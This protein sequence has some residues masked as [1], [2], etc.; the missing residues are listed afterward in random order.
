MIAF[1]TVAAAFVL[2]AIGISAEAQTPSADERAI[3]DLVARY[4]GESALT[5][6]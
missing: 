1:R 6:C 3:R 4:D 5:T 2:A